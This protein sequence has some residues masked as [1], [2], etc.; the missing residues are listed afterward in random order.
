MAISEKTSFFLCS[1]IM[2]NKKQ[3]PENTEQ[4]IC[5]RLIHGI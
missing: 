3:F 1:S 2:R 5:Y 4:I